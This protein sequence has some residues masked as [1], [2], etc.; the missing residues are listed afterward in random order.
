WQLE[1]VRTAVEAFWNWA[2]VDLD[3]PLLVIAVGDEA[4]MKTLAPQ[5]WEQRNGV[6]PASV[7]VSG[8]DRHY[9]ALR[10]DAKV[11]D[12]VG[13]NPY[14][15]AYWSYVNLIIT[16]A[17]KR[18]MPLWLSRGLASVMS[19]TIVREARLDV[20]QPIPWHLQRLNTGSR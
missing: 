1:Q 9:V 12:T 6:R 3:K 20:G 15:V 16:T 13:I 8:L 19:N 17:I 11:P 4:G 2:R 7:F 18:D 5:F 14:V 10:A